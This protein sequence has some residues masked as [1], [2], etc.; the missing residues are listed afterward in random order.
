MKWEMFSRENIYGK[1]FPES[2]LT[3]EL[4]PSAFSHARIRVSIGRKS[5]SKFD[6]ILFMHL[7]TCFLNGT[8]RHLDSFKNYMRQNFWTLTY[9]LT[10]WFSY[11]RYA[12]F[13]VKYF[14]NGNFSDALPVGVKKVIPK[15]ISLNHVGELINYT[16][17]YKQRSFSTQPQCYLTFLWIEL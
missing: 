6:F 8:P 14:L 11:V 12:N 7:F 15:V 13:C 1:C 9:F 5:F 10:H 17:F 3:V 4:N 2:R 16:L